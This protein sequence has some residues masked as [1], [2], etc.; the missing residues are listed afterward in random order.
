MTSTLNRHHGESSIIGL[1]QPTDTV[2]TIDLARCRDD[3]D[4]DRWFPFSP[5]DLAYAQSVCADCPLIDACLAAGISHRE[6]G[7]WGGRYLEK[8]VAVLLPAERR[9]LR[10]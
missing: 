5:E 1:L 9:R 6:F 10:G 7:V 8:G 3:Q 4:R 2:R